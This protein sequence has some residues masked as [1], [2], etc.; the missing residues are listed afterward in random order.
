MSPESPFQEPGRGDRMAERIR[1][2]CRERGFAPE[3]VEE[4]A[5]LHRLAMKP[6]VRELEDDHD[7]RYLHPGRVAAI[8]LDDLECDDP[9]LVALGMV[10]DS[11][12]RELEAPDPLLPE[13]L[14]ARRAT[15][16]RPER[17]DE[18]LEAL[19]TLEPAMLDVVLAERLDHLRHIHLLDDLERARSLY[20]QA[21]ASYA[22]AAARAH[23]VLSR[24]YDWWTR[25]FGR[26]FST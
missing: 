10:L 14:A 8:L 13:E 2:T 6:R 4:L 17:G 23:P 24:R 7:P 1:R 12:D 9:A 19:V 3:A 15:L 16:P 5:R 11:E 20:A 21:A 26:K 25:K 22:A 18:L